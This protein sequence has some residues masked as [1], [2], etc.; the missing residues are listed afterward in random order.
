MHLQ[1]QGRVCIVLSPNGAF[2]CVTKRWVQGLHWLPIETLCGTQLSLSVSVCPC[3]AH[4]RL[5]HTLVQIL[6]WQNCMGVQYLSFFYFPHFAAYQ[7]LIEGLLRVYCRLIEGYWR[8]VGNKFN[9]EYRNISPNSFLNCT[10]HILASW[11]PAALPPACPACRRLLF[12][13]LCLFWLVSFCERIWQMEISQESSHL[14]ETASKMLRSDRRDEG[15]VR[16]FFLSH[17]S[18][19]TSCRAL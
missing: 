10:C 18:H 16:R 13:L 9:R 4:T 3:V 1:R 19:F 14:A 11:L 6:Y 15:M 2:T 5:K 7:R 8:L 12:V 17:T